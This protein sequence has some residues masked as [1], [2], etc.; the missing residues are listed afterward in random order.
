MAST[1]FTSS[2]TCPATP[3][4]GKEDSGNDPPNSSSEAAITK[5]SIAKDQC[6][7]DVKS[8]TLPKTVLVSSEK[9]HTIKLRNVVSAGNSRQNSSLNGAEKAECERPSSSRKLLPFC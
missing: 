9:D 6:D 2:L 8:H 1:G 7:S 4:R 5:K 3:D